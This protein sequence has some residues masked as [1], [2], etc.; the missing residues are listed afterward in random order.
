MPG[1]EVG[2]RTLAGHRLYGHK[3]SDRTEYIS[4]LHFHLRSKEAVEGARSHYV[5]PLYIILRF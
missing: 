3:E 5:G 2:Q 4:L 1:E